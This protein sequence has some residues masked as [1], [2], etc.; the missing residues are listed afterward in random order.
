VNKAD[1]SIDR[2]KKL[3]DKRY[4]AMLDGDVAV[5]GELCSERLI[6]THSRGDNDDKQSYLHKISSGVF[7][8]LE[9]SHPADRIIILEG[10]VLVTGRMTARVAVAEEI[11]TIDNRY[12]AV[13]AIE[14]G[15]WKLIAYQ[16]TPILTA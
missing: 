4:Q 9:I 12:L 5:L 2:I 10:A 1:E 16:P 3:E 14:A 8:Y 13:W 6:Y 7:D 11:R 15:A